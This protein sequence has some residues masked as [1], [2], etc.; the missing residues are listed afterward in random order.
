MNRL[1]IHS[2]DDRLMTKAQA[3]VDALLRDPRGLP[4]GKGKRIKLNPSAAGQFRAQLVHAVGFAAVFAA[5]GPLPNRIRGRG[6]PPDNAYFIFIDD[7]IRACTAVGLKPGLRYV[8]GTESLPVLLFIELASLLWGRM[9]S[10]RR[11]FERWQRNKSNL[12]RSSA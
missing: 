1:L 11:I 6:R 10:P 9:Q 12:T 2:V 4:N 3:R 8:S 7:I 5:N